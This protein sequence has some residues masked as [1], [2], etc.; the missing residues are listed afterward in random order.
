MTPATKH[1]ALSQQL[2]MEIGSGKYQAKGRLPSEAQL[3]KRFE[4]SRP[5]VGRA[6]KDLQEQGLV[7]RRKGSGTYIRPDK[8]SG[9]PRHDGI[10]QLGLI[11]PSL[12]HTE[13]FEPICGELA[14]LSRVHGFGLWSGAEIAPVGESKMTVEEAEALCGRFIEQGVRGVFFVPFEHQADREAA[15]RRITERLKQ[16]GIPVVL[17]DRDIG[18]FPHRSA[19]DL[20]G[21]DN[22]E[23]GYLLAEHLIKLGMRRLAYVMRPLTASTVDARIAGARM[24]MLAHGLESQKGFVQVGD[25]TDL[26]FVRSFAK[27]RQ[28]EAVL[29]T[30][31]HL[32][33]QLLQSLT[34]IG[35]RVPQDLR[36]VGFDDVRYASLLTIPLT[37]MEQPCRDIAITAFNALCERLKN[38]TLPPR[39]LMLAPRL[40][41]RETCG[42]YLRVA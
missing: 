4:V 26:K 15:N 17:L 18:A 39:T 16:A 37:T 13:I 25:P 23:G 3:V 29:C 21:V 30:S 28:L 34:R 41:V 20:A 24:A 38:P 31:D 6:L 14:S 2:A 9:H 19:F 8:G 22:F 27:S 1:R 12:R 33:A 36:L 32:A 42:A 10:P 40:V 11:I 5:T 35:I 7:E